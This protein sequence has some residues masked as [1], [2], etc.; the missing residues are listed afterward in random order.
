MTNKIMGFKE[1]IEKRLF[2]ESEEETPP[3]LE[4]DS[5]FISEN[6][7]TVELFEGGNWV[8]GRFDGNIRIDQPPTSFGMRHAHIYGRK[9][10]LVG[11][12]NVNGTGSHGSKFTLAKKDAS[13][14]RA[15]G[16]KIPNNRVVEWIVID[17]VPELLLG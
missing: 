11:V 1:F 13:A 7:E 16:F 15:K 4:L 8:S 9:G 2:P 12:V 5:L 3:L 10:N 14:L 6:S 17:E